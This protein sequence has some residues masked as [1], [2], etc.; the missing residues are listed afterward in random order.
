MAVRIPPLLHRSPDCRSFHSLP[1]A[2]SFAQKK[3][4]KKKGGAKYPKK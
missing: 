2:A 1:L 4:E 3:K